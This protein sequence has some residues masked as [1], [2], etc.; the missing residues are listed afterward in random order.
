MF[1]LPLC[2]IVF[3]SSVCPSINFMY[4]EEEARMSI[5]S[6]STKHYF[7][8]GCKVSEEISYKIKRMPL[9]L[10]CEVCARINKETA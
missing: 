6:V 4:S 7:A 8:F 5:Y 1:Q 10:Q 3:A 9:G 2:L